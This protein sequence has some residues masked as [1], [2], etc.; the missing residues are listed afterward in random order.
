MIEIEK[1]K[2]M[3]QKKTILVFLEIGYMIWTLCCFC[4]VQLCAINMYQNTNFRQGGGAIFTD[5]VLSRK[6]MKEE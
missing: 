5:L 4:V 6:T 1:V 2:L 3:K